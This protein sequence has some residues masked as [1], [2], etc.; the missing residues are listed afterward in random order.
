MV[1]CTN[2]IT[3][4][5]VVKLFKIDHSDNETFDGHDI[6]EEK[7][8][9]VKVMADIF[10]TLQRQQRVLIWVWKCGNIYILQYYLMYLYFVEISVF[11]HLK[12]KYPISCESTIFHHK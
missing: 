2:T 6:E 10:G 8:Q 7:G 5:S 1:R 4:I 12:G 11:V 9:S 3:S